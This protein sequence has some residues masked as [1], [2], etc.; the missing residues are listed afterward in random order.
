VRS[1]PNRAFKGRFPLGRLPG[2]FGDL[3][4]RQPLLCQGGFFSRL[5]TI[6]HNEYGAFPFPKLQSHIARSRFRRRQSLCR[7]SRLQRRR[8]EIQSVGSITR[9]LPRRGWK[10]RSRMDRSGAGQLHLV[11]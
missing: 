7:A 10:S 5:R 9:K 2:R 6:T 1:H 11:L 8:A 3:M 4:A